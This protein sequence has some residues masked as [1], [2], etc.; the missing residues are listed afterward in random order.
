MTQAI[1]N[2]NLTGLAFAEE[3]SL[4]TLPGSPVWYALEPN[5][6]SDFGAK[7]TLVT[8]NTI[9]PSRQLYKG[10]TAD[11]DA[12]GGFNMDFTQ[13]NLQR[14]MQG[15][16]FANAH[17]KADTASFNSTGIT[18]TST[19]TSTFTAASGLTVFI[20]NSLVLLSGFATASNN[21]LN[22]VS[23]STGT[24]VTVATT[25]VAEASPPAAARAQV[26]GYQFGADDA[27]I[28][29]SGGQ[30]SLT[31]TT[32]DLTTLSLNVGEWLFLGGDTTTLRF[33]NN[34]GWVRI[35]SIAAHT[36]I[37]DKST[38]TPVSETTTGGKTVQIFFGKF[39]RNELTTS[40]IKRRTY[41]IERQLGSDANGVMSEYITGAVT[42]QFDLNIKEATK[43]EA[44]LKFVACG[45]QA[46]NGLTGIKAG[47]RVAA[48]GETA[49]NTSTDINFVNMS[50]VSATNPDP[51]QL[52]GYV[53]DAKLTIKNSV[54]PVKAVGVLGAFDTTQ[55]NFEVTGTINAYFTT[56]DATAAISN[57]SNV[58]LQVFTASNNAGWML[59]MP[60]L[61]LGNGQLNV[62][63]DAPITLPI[64][65][66]AAQNANGYTAAMCFF[67]YLP[68]IAL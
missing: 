57:N 48:L 59:D 3:A 67:S 44:D 53:S 5:S 25:L 11:L 52:F 19:T 14:I 51:S 45:Y 63:K 2:S 22:K 28:V 66:T 10:V 15:F 18:I 43:V 13:T 65:T 68:T 7:Y 6:Y 1:I 31:T 41:Q 35:K 23:S 39:L 27:A 58:D 29:Y 34:Q 61:A 26:V 16:F 47:T 40:L 17:E 55:G 32:A 50:I 42:D 24:A 12:A 60:L 54:K 21:A 30:L 4:L 38:F 8:R 62:T 46:N 56:V 9:N 20:A 64:D 33:V 37:L 36:I 49:F